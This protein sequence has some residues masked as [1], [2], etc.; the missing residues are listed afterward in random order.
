V[1]RSA[2][3]VIS[4][5]MENA[6]SALTTAIHAAMIKSAKFADLTSTFSE[7]SATTSALLDTTSPLESACPATIATA[8]P[9]KEKDASPAVTTTYWKREFAETSA[10]KASSTGTTVSAASAP[11]CACS[12][13]MKASARPVLPAGSSRTADVFRTAVTASPP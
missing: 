6:R 11:I 10:L 12:A 1:W 7:A 5:S 9:A 13:I 8:R 4:L 2:Q 3:S